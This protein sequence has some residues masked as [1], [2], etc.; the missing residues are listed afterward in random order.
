LL[1]ISAPR[2]CQQCHVPTCHPTRPYGDERATN[3]KGNFAYR[4]DGH[5]MSCHVN[6]HGSNHP[7]GF[8]LAR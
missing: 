7:S 1:K 2:I 5:G 4:G 8:G 6:I 3:Q